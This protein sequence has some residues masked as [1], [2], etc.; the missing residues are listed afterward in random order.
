MQMMCHGAEILI[1][2]CNVL[3]FDQSDYTWRRTV[4]GDNYV[5]GL[6]PGARVDGVLCK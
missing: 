5:R 4:H 3:K 1:A 2:Y 6:V